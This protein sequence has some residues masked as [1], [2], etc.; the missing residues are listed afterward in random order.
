MKKRRPQAGLAGI[1]LEL[2]AAVVGGLL[3]GLWIDRHYGTSPWAAV[4]GGTVGIVGGLVNFVRQARRAMEEATGG[5]RGQASG[6][7]GEG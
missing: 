7:G 6:K 4:A 1:G 5:E 3:L 2:T